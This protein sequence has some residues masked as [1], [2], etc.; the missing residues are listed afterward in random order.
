MTSVKEIVDYYI[1]EF[2][3]GRCEDAAFGLAE[4]DFD[5]DVIPELINVY[6]STDD[7]DTKVFVIEVVSD[8]R[9][10]SSF[11]FLRHALHREEQEIWK[12][13]LNGLAMVESADSVDAMDVVLAS[14]TD[15]NKRAWIEEVIS[16]TN[17]TLTRNAEQNAAEQPASRSAVKNK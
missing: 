4:T 7:T 3:A 14:I 15:D 9:L 8:F 16:D 5:S 11:G 2:L 6:E 10:P 17:A 1:S 12:S 13:A